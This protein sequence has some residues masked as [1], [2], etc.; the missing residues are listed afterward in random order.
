MTT[1]APAPHLH[2]LPTI[3]GLTAEFA[4]RHRRSITVLASL[5]LVTGVVHASM[6]YL[7]PSTV[8]TDDEGTYVAQAWAVVKQGSLAHYTYWYDH[9]PLGWL[10]IA[11]WAG[12]TDGFD[13]LDSAIAVGREAMLI[14]K[15]ASVTL[16]YA[17][18]RRLGMSR[19]FA[20]VAV[21]LFAVNPL[22]VFF[23]RLTFLDNV[24]VPWLL[25]AFLLAASPQGRLME[26]VGS[27][28]CF[29]VA[30][31]TKET[32][33]IMVPALVYQ[34]VSSRDQRTRTY[35]N[36][37]FFPV[38][39]LGCLSY[40]L[41]A[42]LKGELFPGPGHVDLLYAVKWQLLDR[43]PS[44][45]VFD[46][47]SAASAIVKSWTNLDP[48]LLGLSIALIPVA[49]WSRRLRPVAAAY[50]I[51]LAMMLRGGYLPQ[52]YIIALLPFSALILAGS[53]NVLWQNEVMERLVLSSKMRGP[54]GARLVVRAA[55][56]IAA[57]V[58][59]WYVAIPEWRPR[60]QSLMTEDSNRSV[61]D[62][63]SWIEENVPLDSTIL[64]SD[65]MWVDLVER[66][67]DSDRVIWYTKADLDP[68][69]QATIPQGWEDIDYVVF[70]NEMNEIA[71]SSDT[72]I[73]TTLR[74]R[75]NGTMVAE[76]G[77]RSEAI[78]V[79]KVD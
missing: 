2:R 46:P 75:E 47:T 53:M 66:G 22:G 17:L 9:P 25:A 14:A 48:W 69:V 10:Q 67:Y 49:I 32:V 28:L 61:Q 77:E 29:A 1:L 55:L 78:W 62:T 59:L 58:A 50:L 40:P 38:M 74:A 56:A 42:L 44:G 11:L 5:L 71:K 3:R 13:R 23:Q 33:A 73:T 16:L 76:F 45:S 7:N 31:L 19:G 12:L 79:Y 63:I 39:I 41:Y 21:L 68:A 6:M 54:S 26:H 27:A 15:L 52:P 72:D 35:S 65:A 51:Q 24:A 30:V 64:V 37:L 70:T 8:V 18:A 34:L 43:I 4:H 20:A 57:V 60:V 36:A